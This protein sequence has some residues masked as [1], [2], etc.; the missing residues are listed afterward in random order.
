[1]RALQC[2]VIAAGLMTVSCAREMPNSPQQR[3]NDTA[4]SGK[5]P[6]RAK[7]PLSENMLGN[8]ATQDSGLLRELEFAEGNVVRFVVQ[9]ESQP[10][11]SITGKYRVSGSVIQLDA[12]VSGSEFWL[13]KCEV[14]ETGD[15]FLLLQET[16]TSQAKPQRF[17]RR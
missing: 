11:R 5:S 3:S 15:G 14:L 9:P 7:R 8:W 2:C 1:M 16:M 6:D 13:L 4:P 17:N 10:L 12:E